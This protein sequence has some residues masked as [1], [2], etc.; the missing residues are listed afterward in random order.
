MEIAAIF[1]GDL[2]CSSRAETDRADQSIAALAGASRKITEWSRDDMH[3]TRF[4]GDGW[5]T[6]WSDPGLVCRA[7]L[8]LPAHLKSAGGGL[9]AR[10]SL[11][12]GKVE[13]I[14][15]TG[16][17]EAAGPALT[18]SGCNL[19]HAMNLRDF[20]YSEPGAS[21]FCKI[22]TQDLAH[23]QASRCS[24]EQ[25]E[26]PCLAHDL[27]RQPDAGLARQLGISRQALQA[28]LKEAG[29]MAT[30]QA[31]NALATEVD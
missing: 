10:M 4:R 31:P 13:W 7:A 23:W 6:C 26:A 18:L 2:I 27:S 14:G 9:S 21:G 16:P 25:A 1:T 22:A 17:S 20:V 8:P 11:A 24:P 15:E 5:L 29:L 3:F 30:S 28:R 12:G 19:D